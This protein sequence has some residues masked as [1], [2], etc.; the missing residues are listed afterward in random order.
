MFHIWNI[1]PFQN[2]ETSLPTI[3]KFWPNF[4]LDS[5]SFCL[6]HYFVYSLYQLCC[7]IYSLSETIGYCAWKWVLLFRLKLYTVQY[8]RILATNIICTYIQNIHMSI[9]MV[10]MVLIWTI[11]YL[12]WVYII[13]VFAISFVI[14]VCVWIHNE[15][16]VLEILWTVYN[17]YTYNQLEAETWE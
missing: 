15:L 13:S 11:A 16:Y 6:L 3:N 4:W 17:T 7:V 8:A 9:Q 10:C 14:C 12:I 1:T 2:D 5:A